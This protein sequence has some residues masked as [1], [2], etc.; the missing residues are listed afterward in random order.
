[1]DGQTSLDAA[2]ICI[3]VLNQTTSSGT[4]IASRPPVEMTRFCA[5]FGT[6]EPP[7]RDELAGA[8][9]HASRYLNL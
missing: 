4:R 1:M 6:I 2:N 5:T 7:K 8:I 3:Q 9:A